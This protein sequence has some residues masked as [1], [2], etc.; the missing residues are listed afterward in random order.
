M[1]SSSNLSMASFPHDVVELI[2]EKLAVKSL[3]RF[4]SVSK[5]WKSTI[6]SD[7]DTSKKDI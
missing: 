1:A 7:P 5:Q 2:L 6:E 4:K 3:L